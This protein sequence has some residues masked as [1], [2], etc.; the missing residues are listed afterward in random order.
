MSRAP[1]GYI[2]W[3]H[4]SPLLDGLGE[5]WQHASTTGRFGFPV[6]EPKL[7]ARELLHAGAI[8]TIADVC[9]GHTMAA[10]TDPPTPLVTANLNVTFV[11]AGHRD[12]WIDVF[13]QAHRVGRRLATGEVTFLDED[14]IVAHATA[15]FIPLPR[16]P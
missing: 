14:R 9:L 6:D 7:N 11:G 3:P 8:S 16:T 4:P 1:A 10:A 13:A 12:R 5:L 15:V 2:A